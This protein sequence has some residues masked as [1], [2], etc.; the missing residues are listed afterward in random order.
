MDDQTLYQRLRPALEEG[1]PFL[2]R[3]GLR[4]DSIDWGHVKLTCPLGPN[5]NH[6]GTMYAGALF[7]LAEVPGGAIF[8]ST[9]DTDTYYPIVKR[10]DIRYLKPATTDVSVEVS[11]TSEEVERIQAGARADG[12]ADYSWDCVLTDT[13]G[14][15]VARSTNDYQLRR[16]GS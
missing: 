8:L 2:R 15:V 6:I 5:V 11:I 3:M 13:A 12:R 4:L 16:H 7:T 10:M 1:L 14:V 9:F